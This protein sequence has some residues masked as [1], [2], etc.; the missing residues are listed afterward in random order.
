MPIDSCPSCG[1]EIYAPYVY[2]NACSW[3]AKGKQKREI[4]REVERERSSKLRKEKGRREPSR[5]N[6]RDRDEEWEP[7]PSEEPPRRKGRRRPSEDEYED[8]SA[9]SSRKG[10]RRKGKRRAREDKYEDWAPAPSRKRSGRGRRREAPPEEEYEEWEAPRERRRPPKRAKPMEIPCKCGG[11]IVVKSNK[12]PINIECPECGRTGTL[13]SAPPEEPEPSEDHGRRPPRRSTRAQKEYEEQLW[14]GRE[15]EVKYCDSCGT[16]LSRD[17]FCPRCGTRREAHTRKFVSYDQ[18]YSEPYGSPYDQPYEHPYSEP[19][20][21]QDYPYEREE[22]GGFFGRRRKPAREPVAKK[23][24][25]GK[26]KDCG[27]KNLQFYDDGTGRCPNCGRTF[28]WHDK[29]PRGGRPDYEEEPR[30]GR[31]RD[32]DRGR[33]RRGGGRKKP[34]PSPPP[35]AAD[36]DQPADEFYCPECGLPMRYIPEYQQYYC[37][38]CKEYE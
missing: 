35:S 32:K 37:D 30:G 7:V 16:R 33:G 20:E 31:D 8:W 13:K 4:E 17:D 38:Y 5:R 14:G 15:E 11:T 24:R 36:Y 28:Q 21:S 2:C 25:K 27:S 22:K 10:S 23:P 29:G 34:Q 9:K 3:E 26:C 19:P 12:R 6:K 1:N 18:P